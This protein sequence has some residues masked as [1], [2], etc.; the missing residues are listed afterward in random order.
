M[1]RR[2]TCHNSRAV[3]WHLDNTSSEIGNPY[4]DIAD[5]ARCTGTIACDVPTGSTVTE[6]MKAAAMR[7]RL[8]IASRRATTC[9]MWSSPI[10]SPASPGD[11]R[12]QQGQSH[13]WGVEKRGRLSGLFS[14]FDHCAGVLCAVWTNLTPSC[15]FPQ[16][17]LDMI[18]QY[19]T[20]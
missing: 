5:E 19:F 15:S 11:R 4:R 16:E 7:M 20:G 18:N 10:P 8:C 6:R 14:S 12:G 2:D 9:S 1:C 13:G 17:V 3:G